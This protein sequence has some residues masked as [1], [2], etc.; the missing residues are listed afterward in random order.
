MNRNIPKIAAILSLTVSLTLLGH[1]ADAK[2]SFTPLKKGMQSAK[3][4]E[5]EN[6]LSALKFS[7]KLKVDKIYNGYTAYNVKNFQKKYKLKQTGIVNQATYDKLKKQYDKLKQTGNNPKTENSQKPSNNG[8]QPAASNPP[9]TPSPSPEQSQKPDWQVSLP[10]ALNADEKAMVQ[11]VN[12]ARADQGLS[13]LQVDMKLEQAARTKAEDMIKSGYFS[14]TSPTY[15]SPFDMMKAFGISYRAAAEN[16]AQNRTVEAGH[17]MLMNSAGHRANILN[18]SFSHIAIAVVD[19]G[20]YG[21][22]FVQMF[23]KY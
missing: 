19:G 9:T 18:S 8:Q 5:V 3:V 21:K 22:T 1:T 4:L 15:G 6:M 12:Q 7:Y 16:I 13:P 11:L 23:V 20:P 2:T 17:Q 14:H 10:S